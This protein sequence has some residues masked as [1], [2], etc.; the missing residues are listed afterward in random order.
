M[1]IPIQLTLQILR[2]LEVS[3]IINLSLMN[4]QNYINYFI[5]NKDYLARIKLKYF[6]LKSKDGNFHIYNK[7]KCGLYKQ[8]LLNYSKIL[9]DNIIDGHLPVVQ[10]LVN[11]GIKTYGNTL[12]YPLRWSVKSGH[13]DIVKFFLYEGA[14]LNSLLLLSAKYGHLE[15]LKYLVSLGA[16]IRTYNEEIELM[17]FSEIQGRNVDANEDYALIQSARNGHLPVVKY[18]VSQGINVN[19]NNSEALIL[20]AYNGHLEVVKFLVDQ[21]ADVNAQEDL[22]LRLSANN[23]YLKVVKYLVYQGANFYNIDLEINS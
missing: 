20:S 3:E 16:D 7:I 10:F 12:I 18:L 6:G 2:Y 4:I 13:L 8:H 14:N 5:N 22:A 15:V 23:R 11:S 19:V 17:G 21:G 9:L 1:T